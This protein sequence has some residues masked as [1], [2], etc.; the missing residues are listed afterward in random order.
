MC[1]DVNT[2]QQM[3]RQ[4]ESHA[5]DIHD[6]DFHDRLVISGSRD[7]TVKVTFAPLAHMVETAQD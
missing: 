6:V 5:S 7:A 1:V 3:W 4:E 2:G